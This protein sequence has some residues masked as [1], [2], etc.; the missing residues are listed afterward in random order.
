MAKS[1]LELYDRRIAARRRRDYYNRIFEKELKWQERLRN[2]PIMTGGYMRP[3]V[4]NPPLPRL[5]PQPAHISGMIITRKRVRARRQAES[6]YNQSILEEMALEVAFEKQLLQMHPQELR[7]PVFSNAEHLWVEHTR[8][9][10]S[11]LKKHFYNETQRSLTPFSPE[12]VK[13]IRNARREKIRNKT[14]ERERERR[15]EL[16]KSA[17]KRLRKAPP[18]RVR[19]VLKPQQLLEDAVRR[20]PSEGGWTGATKRRLGM[21]LKVDENAYAR[22]EDGRAGN[23]AALAWQ[24]RQVR[25]AN[26][27]RGINVGQTCS[28]KSW[29]RSTG[30]N[31]TYRIRQGPE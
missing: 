22:K 9:H 8:R 25:I 5:K 11:E 18:A 24:E 7:E 29:N 31:L 21:R 4:Y 12:M 30:P 17:M 14:H 19:T 2:R 1:M 28:S 20:S 15:G 26:S 10:Q 16:T 6:V 3:T 23:Q 27:R 13:M